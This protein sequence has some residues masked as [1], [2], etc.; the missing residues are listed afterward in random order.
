MDEL[1][2][3]KATFSINCPAKYSEDNKYLTSWEK[4]MIKAIKEQV[5]EEIQK[6]KDEEKRLYPNRGVDVI[7]CDPYYK[8][9]E[10]RTNEIEKAYRINRTLKILAKCGLDIEEFKKTWMCS[11]DRSDMLLGCVQDKID[12]FDYD[13]EG[14]RIPNNKK[15]NVKNMTVIYEDD[16][17]K[18][19]DGNYTNEFKVDEHQLIYVN[20]ENVFES[21]LNP[22]KTRDE[23]RQELED[24][25]NNMEADRLN[26]E[27]AEQKSLEF[28]SKFWVK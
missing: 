22:I 24:F 3:V 23:Q 9:R 7:Y 17:L 14:A 12:G 28:A 10:E 21:S 27:Y 20:G 5:E 19:S 15:M 2:C 26:R 1:F 18:I 25:H 8:Y 6:Q 11:C 13:Q 4:R 16:A